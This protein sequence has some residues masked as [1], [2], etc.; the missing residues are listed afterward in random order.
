M[1][2]REQPPQNPP[3]VM[4]VCVRYCKRGRARF[5]SHR[6][7]ARALERALRRADVPMAYSSGFNP[8]PRI[9][10]PGASQTGAATEA[11]YVELGLAR[12]VDTA[13]LAEALSAALPEGM[14]VLGVAVR[15][16]GDRTK[17]AD[18]L[19]ASD[20]LVEMAES[21]PDELAAAVAGLLG[22]AEL[23]VSRT[24][25]AGVRHFDARGAILDL[26]IE[27]PA[28]LRLTLRHGTPLVR[29]DD[30][31]SALRQLRPESVPGAGARF[32]RLSQ[33]LWRDGRI[34]PPFED[35]ASG[36]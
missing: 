30:V 26:A 3:P 15:E 17:L 8:H 4:R 6:D 24:T 11:D 2:Q 12:P 7:F 23:E 21:V 9:S 33:G 35:Q 16:P 13:W 34:V 25:G 31:L 1:A 10:Y 28:S 36:Q 19:D 20:W 18:L 22:R 5:A 14:E 27:G 29:P 32:T